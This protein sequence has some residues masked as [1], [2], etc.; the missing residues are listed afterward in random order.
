[1]SRV[2]VAGGAGFLGSHLCDRLV[3]RGDEVVCVDDLSTGRR[4]ERGPPGRRPALRAGRGRRERRRSRWTGRVDAVV[5]PGQPGLATGLPGAAARDPGRRERGDPAPARA[6]RPPRGPGSCWPPPA[7]STAT[8]RSTPSARPTGA[9]WTPS[10]RAASTTRP[11]GSPR[12][13]PWPHHRALGTDVAIARIFNTYGP[14]LRPATAGWCPTSSSR[15]WP[16]EPLT[17]YGDGSQTRSL[18]YVD[19]EVAGLL[20]LLDSDRDRAGQH[21]QPRRAHRARAGRSGC[22]RSPARRPRSSTAPAGRRP[23]PAVPGHLPGPDQA[24]LGAAST[25]AGRGAGAARSEHFAAQGR[26]RR[27]GGATVDGRGGDRWLTA[28]ARRRSSTARCR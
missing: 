18:C 7:R 12:P 22:S 8:P 15:R 3:A 14:R 10:G 1:M 2:V 6:G 26:R 23:R 28:I 24:R 13:S 27:L 19:D 21:R 20:A 16:A 17:V 5:Q 11:S 4:H 25:A 9:T